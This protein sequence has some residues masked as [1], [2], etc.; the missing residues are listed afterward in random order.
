MF[1]HGWPPCL[2]RSVCV[3]VCVCLSMCVCVSVCKAAAAVTEGGPLCVPACALCGRWLQPPAI[4]SPCQSGRSG[5]QL[6]C[7]C[8][9]VCV[10]PCVYSC[11]SVTGDVRMKALKCFCSGKRKP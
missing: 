11:L 8:V 10:Y 6:L 3:C 9:C 1:F 5:P 4:I 2:D 7:V